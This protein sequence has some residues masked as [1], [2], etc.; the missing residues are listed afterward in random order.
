MNILCIGYYDKHSRFFLGIKRQLKKETSS[1]NFKIHSIH[2]SGFLYTLFRL[3]F[4]CW[5]PMKSWALAKKN[6]KKYLNLIDSTNVYKNIHYKRLIEFHSNLNNGISKKDLLLQTLSYIDFFEEYFTNNKTDILLLIGDSR[7]SIEACIAVCKKVS[8]NVKIYY[9]EKGAFNSTIFSSKGVNANL[10]IDCDFNLSI[11][12]KT[13]KRISEFLN[14][15]PKTKSN[16][17]YLYRFFDFLSYFLTSN[18]LL[19]LPP[20]LKNTDTFPLNIS[21]RKKKLFNISDDSGKLFLLVLQVPLDVNMIYHSPFFKNHLS[22]VQEVFKNLPPSCQLLVREHPL[23]KGK[24]EKELYEFIGHNN[25]MI[26][27]N[28]NL[29]KSLDIADIIIVNNSTVGFEAICLKKTVVVLGNA[30][31]DKAELCLKY[32]NNQDLNE[33]LFTSL[34]FK[35]N[36]N[37]I[38]SFLAEF[39]DKKIVEG[40]IEDNDFSA[41]KQIAE[42]LKSYHLRERNLA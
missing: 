30:F 3:K 15:T 13:E 20:D 24:Y 1:L 25:I 40:S 17:S 14:N 6:K 37:Y 2:L 35:P 33:V 29:K 8:I 38:L 11:T 21:I 39:I 4:S 9:I 26:D 42:K 31:Y 16:R 32:K 36:K 5:L 41:A 7:L 34:K 27:T 19:T 12:E 18:S 23:Y 10:N 22:I 28:K